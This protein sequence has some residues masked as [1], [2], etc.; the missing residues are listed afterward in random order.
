MK[1]GIVVGVALGL[2]F[3]IGLIVLLTRCSDL[4]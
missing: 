1:P 3:A 2:L 4:V